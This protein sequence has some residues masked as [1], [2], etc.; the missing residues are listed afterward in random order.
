MLRKRKRNCK[1]KRKRGLHVERNIN[2]RKVRYASTVEVLPQEADETHV[3]TLRL[4]LRLRYPSS[5]LH[6]VSSGFY[7]HTYL[8][9]MLYTSKLID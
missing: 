8:K 7:I 3:F 4:H 5:H 6:Y 2:A 1:R 9:L